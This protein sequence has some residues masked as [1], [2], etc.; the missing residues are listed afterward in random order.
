MSNK[1]FFCNGKCKT[2]KE[3][4]GL[5]QEMAHFNVDGIKVTGSEYDR[6]IFGA[7]LDAMNVQQQ[8]IVGVQKAVEESRNEKANSDYKTAHTVAVGMLGLIHAVTENEKSLGNIK[9]LGK[10]AKHIEK[11]L[12]AE[13]NDNKIMEGENIN[14]RDSTGNAASDYRRVGGGKQTAEDG[15]G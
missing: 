14:E 1:G 3:R 10:I 7:I 2:L 12:T 6:C 11:K 15:D 13:N 9:R 8:R 5:L 4:C